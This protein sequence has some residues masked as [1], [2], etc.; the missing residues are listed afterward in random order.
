MLRILI[1]EKIKEYKTQNLGLERHYRSASTEPNKQLVALSRCYHYNT[2]ARLSVYEF[3]PPLSALVKGINQGEMLELSPA[4]GEAIQALWQV[5]VDYYKPVL[6]AEE[7][8]ILSD[9]KMP[10][11]LDGSFQAERIR[12]MLDQYS[13]HP[14]NEMHLLLTIPNKSPNPE[15]AEPDVLSLFRA[16]NRITIHSLIPKPSE[17]A[18]GD[19][20]F[21]FTDYDNHLRLAVQLEE[22]RFEPMVPF[23]TRVQYGNHRVS[24]PKISLHNQGEW[25]QSELTFPKSSFQI[26][27]CPS[28]LLEWL[29]QDSSPARFGYSEVFH[30]TRLL[31][32]CVSQLRQPF[33]SSSETNTFG[34]VFKSTKRDNPYFVVLFNNNKNLM[35]ITLSGATS[36]SRITLFAKSDD[37]AIHG[38]MVDIV[39]GSNVGLD[40][41]VPFDYKS[42]Y[43]QTIM[44]RNNVD[45]VGPS[46]KIYNRLRQCLFLGLKGLLPSPLKLFELLKD[47][48]PMQHNLQIYEG[49]VATAP[50]IESTQQQYAQFFAAPASSSNAKPPK[51]KE[52]HCCIIC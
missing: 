21:S 27:D 6:S 5:I 4:E 49:I 20:V 3:L 44:E 46:W 45:L 35:L 29:E 43:T 34:T 1:N 12:D 15:D 36:L 10:E 19:V 28:E 39:P 8:F 42:G 47:I 31:S 26:T 38:M 11:Y 22:Q 7:L 41:I 51:E 17:L 24:Y 2:D 13:R 9:C 30:M 40:R 23:V 25:I 14:E 50:V 37:G 48:D 16:A 32:V 52:G 33:A 18:E